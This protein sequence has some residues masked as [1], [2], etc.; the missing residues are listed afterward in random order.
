M[1]A[2]DPNRLR[3][4]LIEQILR[5]PAEQLLEVERVLESLS[6]LLPVPRVEQNSPVSMAQRDWPHAPLHRFSAEGTY[7][8][9]AATSDN[10]HFFQGAE[11]LDYLETQTL[12]AL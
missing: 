9:T 11:R 4:Q 6:R 10:A 3:L 7:I 8:V 12:A 1:P 5:L 2:T